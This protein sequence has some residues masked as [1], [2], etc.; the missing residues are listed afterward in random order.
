MIEGVRITDLKIIEDERGSVR[1]M[2]TWNDPH[3]DQFGEIYFS[4]IKTGV[5]KA[6]HLHK[7]MTLNYACVRG[8]VMVGLYDLRSESTTFGEQRKIYLADNGSNYRLLTIPPG[9]WNGFRQSADMVREAIFDEAWIANC[10][11][12]PHDP[13]EITRMDPGDFPA[14]FDWGIYEVAG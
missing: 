11:T 1:H 8:E 7:R 2:L 9:V 13:D 4:T 10:S 14:T 12:L 5:V 6:W 3:F